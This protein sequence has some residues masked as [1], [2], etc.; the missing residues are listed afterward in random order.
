VEGQLEGVSLS[1]ESATMWP[2]PRS[3]QKANNSPIHDTTASASTILIKKKL[4]MA[5]MMLTYIA[6]MRTQTTKSSAKLSAKSGDDIE[7]YPAPVG[8]VCCL[9]LHDRPLF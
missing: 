7:D 6:E 8:W 2:S 3:K 5:V 4:L 1:Q 9:V